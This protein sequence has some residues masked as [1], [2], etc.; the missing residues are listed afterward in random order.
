MVKASKGLDRYESSGVVFRE[1]SISR[2]GGGESSDIPA[3]N[4]ASH[5][6]VGRPTDQCLAVWRLRLIGHSQL[7]LLRLVCAVQRDC[8]CVGGGG[9]IR[10]KVGLRVSV[11]EGTGHKVSGT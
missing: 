4:H 6:A 7:P 11:V 2:S 8:V 10:V 9:G 1:R 5:V 3:V